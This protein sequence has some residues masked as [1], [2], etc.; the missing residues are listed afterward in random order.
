MKSTRF[1]Y[2]LC[3]V[4]LPYISLSQH[5]SS[6]NY[7]VEDGLPSNETYAVFEDYLG[8][9]WIGTDHGVARFDG[10]TFSVFTT[11]DG[12]PDNTILDFYEDHENRLWFLTLNGK[13][14][15]YF[16]DKFTLVHTPES[17]KKSLITGISILP[18]NNQLSVLKKSEY[19]YAEYTEDGKVISYSSSSIQKDLIEQI[20]NLYNVVKNGKFLTLLEVEGHIVYGDINKIF[21]YDSLMQLSNKIE[22][23]LEYGRICRLHKNN[24][25]YYVQTWKG[26]VFKF[27]DFNGSTFE[28][29]DSPIGGDFSTE[30]TDRF[31][32][33]WVSSLN[34]GIYYC[35]NTRISI[36]RCPTSNFFAT[37]G[38][39]NLFVN[40]KNEFVVFGL[41]G[42]EIKRMNQSPSFGHNLAYRMQSLEYQNE[43]FIAV[44]DHKGMILNDDAC[45]V[46]T[47]S[48]E[49]VVGASDMFETEN[50]SMIACY[51]NKIKI[52]DSLIPIIGSNRLDCIL[53][54]RDTIWIGGL[55]GLFSV[56][57]TH[58]KQLDSNFDQDT[59]LQN[60]ITDLEFLGN[61]L[62][63]ATR[64]AGLIVKSGSNITQIGLSN[65]I[66]S[67]SIDQIET[68]GENVAWV[69]SKAG[70]SA[71]RFKSFHP[72]FYEIT[73]LG[74]ADGILRK[75][76][77]QMQY[78]N[79]TLHILLDKFLLKL[80][81]N[82][83][84]KE[85]QQ[86]KVY[87]TSL[88]INSKSK[89]IQS[90]L[91]LSH[92][93][94]SLNFGFTGLYYPNPEGLVYSYSLDNGDSWTQT[95]N[96]RISFLNL[97]KGEYTLLLRCITQK[98]IQSNVEKITFC[99]APPYWE[100]WWFYSAFIILNCCIGFV[101]FRYR[102]K[103][104]KL[105]NKMIQTELKALR[106]QM[107]PHF[108]FNTLNSIQNFVL[109]NESR[110]AVRYISKFAKLMRL[111]LDNSRSEFL[112]I[113]QEIRSLE[114]Y[115]DLERVRL[116]N[117]FDYKIEVAD[118]IDIETC[119][120]PSI[121]LQPYVENA[122]WH[123]V[124]NK[125]EK[126]NIL[127]SIFLREDDLI[128]EI[129]DDGIGRVAAMAIK[130]KIETTHTSHGMNIANERSDLINSLSS[131]QIS[132][133][134][135]DLYDS[136]GN[137]SG[138]KVEIIIKE[139]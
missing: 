42:R 33:K 127:V 117:K 4:L 36:A 67:N 40:Q 19:A 96:R 65:G 15:Y 37:N 57:E 23:P 54:Q 125:K 71:I 21:V 1:L 80:S 50:G 111:I 105:K 13:L 97:P 46:D 86:P 9:I 63:I 100:S 78:F 114:L 47:Q 116:K 109:K 70:I 31:G 27:S 34:H 91:N 107:N 123:G 69:S 43:K 64:G 17:H 30:Y 32:G 5:L 139:K 90:S 122:I 126:G 124:S 8:F 35:P 73:K 68:N 2:I 60:R 45:I 61:N 51:R 120:I 10:Y 93:E 16:E 134:I 14:G 95:E 28:I 81:E 62:L 89:K 103:Q 77:R 12:L 85:R 22:I 128:C 133:E 92:K 130:G 104:Q 24:K 84:P 118:T 75:D 53:A 39:F 98:G 56:S 6:V 18:E 38:K 74:K 44:S 135:F 29:F 119:K 88:R 99:I 87:F 106:S 72:L 76:I 113:K 121:M 20:E 25:F 55:N 131:K 129:V 138:T 66:N 59:L 11:D 82:S 132:T 108:T 83:K 48:N 3:L 94:N 101:I 26:W 79:D 112:T 49:K 115:L 137:A 41:D 52:G 102:L 110:N 7:T 136:N 58:F